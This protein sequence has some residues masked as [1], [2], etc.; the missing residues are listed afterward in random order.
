MLVGQ[1]KEGLA[2]HFA[3]A[4]LHE[5]F[6]LDLAEHVIVGLEDERRIG[7]H[8]LEPFNQPV[9]IFTEL[10]V[11]KALHV[12]VVD[13]DGENYQVR[14]EKRHLFFELGADLFEV[15]VD[16]RTVDAYVGVDDTRRVVFGKDS[17]EGESGPC[18]FLDRVGDG[19]RFREAVVVR[20]V[21]GVLFPFFVVDVRLLGCQFG[22]PVA[23]RR[24]FG[25]GFFAGEAGGV[26]HVA[27]PLKHGVPRHLWRCVLQ[28][29]VLQVQNVGRNFCLFGL[30]GIFTVQNRTSSLGP[31]AFLV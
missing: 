9:V 30:A 15:V 29:C 1:H 23:G 25:L 31:R 6:P 13:A 2:G 3:I 28:L 7:V 27:F 14:L 12:G 20:I 8:L 5:L 16:L 19:G 22:A 24:I 26:Q 18:I 17:C 4:V 21:G 10:L 11:V